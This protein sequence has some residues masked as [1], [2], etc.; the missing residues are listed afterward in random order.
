MHSAPIY[1]KKDMEMP[2]V[3]IEENPYIFVKRFL[4]MNILLKFFRLCCL[5][6]LKYKH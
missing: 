6:Y 1:L 2:D 4:F 3:C 5:L